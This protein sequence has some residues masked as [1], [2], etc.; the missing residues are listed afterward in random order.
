MSTFW[1]AVA[2]KERVERCKLEQQLATQRLQEASSVLA[3]TLK[4]CGVDLAKPIN[5]N[6]DTETVVNQ[7]DHGRP[8]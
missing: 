8:A 7:D 1:K 6:Y 3:A 4:D 5:F 2:A